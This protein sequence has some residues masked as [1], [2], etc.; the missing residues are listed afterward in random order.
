MTNPVSPTTS[1]YDPNRLLDALIDRL[2]LKNDAALARLLGVNP[3][4][5]SKIRHRRLEVGASLLIRMHEETGL[6]VRDL[7]E[8]MGDRRRNHRYGDGL[9][10]A[11]RKSNL[12][13]DAGAATTQPTGSPRRERR[14]EQEETRVS[15]QAEVDS[16]AELA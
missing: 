5:I 16:N 12:Q 8:M 2:R 9:G 6:N 3:P 1:T 10:G 13:R 4:T 11:K 14:A 7:R 15:S